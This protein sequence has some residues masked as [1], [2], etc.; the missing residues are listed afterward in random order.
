[1]EDY[2]T[3]NISAVNKHNQLY[4]KLGIAISENIFNNRICKREMTF[5]N[6]QSKLGKLTLGLNRELIR[7]MNRGL[8]LIER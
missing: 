2:I 4:I 5:N 1:M 3:G 7:R 6:F 8:M